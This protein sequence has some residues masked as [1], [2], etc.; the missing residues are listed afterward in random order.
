[1]K[2]GRRKLGVDQKKKLWGEKKYTL[3][4]KREKTRKFTTLIENL[5]K[6]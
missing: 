6:G 5:F 2:K 3:F 1:M 4:V